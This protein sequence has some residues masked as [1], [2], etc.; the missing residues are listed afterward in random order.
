MRCES[1]TEVGRQ[2]QRGQQQ[3]D[4]GTYKA[5]PRKGRSGDKMDVD[6]ARAGGSTPAHC[7][8]AELSLAGGTNWKSLAGPQGWEAAWRRLD[9]FTNRTLDR[10]HSVPDKVGTSSGAQQCSAS[11][12]LRASGREW[13]GPSLPLTDLIWETPSRRSFFMFSGCQVVRHDDYRR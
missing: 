8:A 3:I 9:L 2:L 13:K 5:V 11:Y 10:I 12:L 6:G 1:R 7:T 4:N